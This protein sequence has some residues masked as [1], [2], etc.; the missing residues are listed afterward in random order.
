MARKAG[1]TISQEEL[2]PHADERAPAGLDDAS[3]LDLDVEEESPFLRAQKRVS[4]R[5]ASLPRRTATR[6]AWAVLALII[7]ALGGVVV[8]AAYHY[9]EHSWRFRVE[10]SDDIEITGLSNVTRSQVIEVMGGD[11]GRNVF[12]VPLAQRRK[13]LEQIPWVES[14]SVMRFVPNRLRIQIHERTPAAFARVGSRIFL[15]DASGVLMELP[16]ASK[17]KFS[18]PVVLGMNLGE[19]QAMRAGRMKIYNRLVTE[20][21]STG[22]HYSQ[23]LSEVDL[24]DADDVK[25]LADDAHGEV[26]VHLGASDFLE[27]FRIYV[28]H[29]QEWRQQFARLDSVDLRYEHQ[30][31]VNP[32]LQGAARQPPLSASVARTAMAAGVK[33][34]ALVSH[35]T[36]TTAAG[37]P[38]AISASPAAQSVPAKKKSTRWRKKQAARKAVAPKAPPASITTKEPAAQQPVVQKT[39]SSGPAASSPT[40]PSKP[41]PAIPKGQQQ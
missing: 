13:Q 6:L 36:V 17:K 38:S 32:D 12:F 30:V 22:A 5:R 21:D 37:P 19:P 23:N 18:F 7:L 4:V 9:G 11:I 24:S 29:V 41:S 25:V 14:A 27:R 28:S 16:V 40:K 20:L 2:Y 8:A 1:S 3:L 33:P 39:A 15:T 34:S 31:V 35:E 10:S 26:L